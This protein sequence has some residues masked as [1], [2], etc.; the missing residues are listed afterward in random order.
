MDTTFY[1]QNAFAIP[2]IG[3]FGPDGNSQESEPLFLQKQDLLSRMVGLSIWVRVGLRGRSQSGDTRGD[4]F[5][6]SNPFQ[7]MG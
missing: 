1:H 7:H 5:F 4:S 2:D 3:L 6:S